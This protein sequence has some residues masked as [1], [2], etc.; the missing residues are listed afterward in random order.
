MKDLKFL[1]LSYNGLTNQLEA[2]TAVRKEGQTAST[3]MFDK[4]DLIN[5]LAV[6]KAKD[7]RSKYTD[8]NDMG[9]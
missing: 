9:N 4:T 7:T 3:L 2:K 5:A 1:G 8:T 6:R